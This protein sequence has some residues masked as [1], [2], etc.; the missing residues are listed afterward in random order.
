M[1]HIARPVLKPQSIAGA[2]DG[3]LPAERSTMH[4]TWRVPTGNETLEMEQRRLLKVFVILAASRAAVENRDTVQHSSLCFSLW[5]HG[6]RI[7][8]VLFSLPFHIS[9]RTTRLPI[10]SLST[11]ASLSSCLVCTPRMRNKK[12]SHPFL[13]GSLAPWLS[14][15]HAHPAA[16]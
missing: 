3:G 11:P 1:C 15:R 6:V 4:S 8:G 13:L 5:I 2:V 7:K 14:R 9:N 10:R 12:I 16:P